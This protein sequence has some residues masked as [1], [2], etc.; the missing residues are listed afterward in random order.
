VRRKGNS[1]ERRKPPNN[2]NSNTVD[3]MRASAFSTMRF[4]KQEGERR[5]ERRGR[6]GVSFHVV[7][8]DLAL[9]LEGDK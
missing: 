3:M 4:Q 7:P 2:H 6:D 5:R 8:F 9:R 1:R